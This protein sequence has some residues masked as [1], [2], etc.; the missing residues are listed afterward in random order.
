MVIRNPWGF[1]TKHLSSLNHRLSWSQWIGDALFKGISHLQVH[2]SLCNK[3]WILIQ[4]WN[5]AHSDTL[6]RMFSICRP[7]HWSSLLLHRAFWKQFI[8]H[9]RMHC[10]IVIVQNLYTKTFKTLLHVSILRSFAGSTC[11]SLLKLCV[12]KINTLLYV[13][14]MQQHIVC[15]CICCI[16]CREVG[17]SVGRP[18]CNRY[19]I[20]TY[21][22]YAAASPNH[23]IKYLSL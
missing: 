6:A 1:S 2:M 10:Y 7:T 19:N 3:F 8:T 23:I 12:K 18:P 13:S 14:V 16:C 22:R 4:R 5:S 20:Y 11:C 15:M 9:Q 17:R 21:T